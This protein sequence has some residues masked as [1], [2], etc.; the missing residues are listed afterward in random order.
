MRVVADVLCAIF[1]TA[2]SAECFR[3]LQSA[4][5]RPQRGYFKLCFSWYFAALVLVQGAAV[6]LDFW[7]FGC[8]VNAVL[9]GALAVG[10]LLVRRKCPLKLTKRIWRQL[11]VQAILLLSLCVF[12]NSSWWVWLLPVVTLVSWAICLPTEL[13]VNRHYLRKACAKLAK[14]NVTVIAVTG[15]YGKTSV[16]DM[17]SSLL[18]DCVSPMGSCNTPLGIAA[19]VNKTDI[20]SARYLVLEFGA[21]KRGDIAQLCKLFRPSVGI[22]TGVCEQHLSTFKTFRNIVATKREL[23]EHL[24]K[25]GFCVLNARDETAR[26]FADAGVCAKHLSND[27]LKTVCKQVNFEGT[28]LTVESGGEKREVTLPHIADYVAD[29]FAIC[30]QTALR[31]GQSLEQTVKNACRVRPTPH[32]LELKRANGFYILDDS[33][34]GSIAGVTSCA[35]T[36]DKFCCS[37]VVVTQGLAECGRL[38]RQLNVECGRILGAACDVAVVLGKNK[39]FLRE[40]LEQSGCKTICADSLNQAVRLALPFVQGGVLLFQNDLPDVAGL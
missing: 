9:F 29:V 18:K 4:S 37:K 28:T 7:R 27:G 8:Y 32:R 36:L 30:A 25:K 40:G 34:N 33:Y 26:S 21:R 23:V 17:L 14:S 38:R 19:Y 16:K 10:C 24:P 5:Y 20:C 31:L 22:V 39:G 13:V 15:S 1:L 11:A 2:S 6:A 12:V 3:T 35:K